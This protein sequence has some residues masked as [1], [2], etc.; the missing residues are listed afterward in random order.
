[1]YLGTEVSVTINT[2]PISGLQSCKISQL[3]NELIIIAVDLLLVS[4][5]ILRECLIINLGCSKI[6]RKFKTVTSNL[7][8]HSGNL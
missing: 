1:M 4:D 3:N 8:R 6:S 5:E 2:N 7:R